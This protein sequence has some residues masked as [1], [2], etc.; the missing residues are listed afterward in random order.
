MDKKQTQVL[1]WA[2]RVRDF[3][4]DHVINSDLA[5]LTALRKELDDGVG[6]LT[7]NAAAQE[8]ITKQSRVQT[9]EITRLRNTL[10]DG[11]LKPIVRMSR[12][13]TLAINGIEI[14]FVLPHFNVDSERLAATGD[15]MVTALNVVVP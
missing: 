10:R 6:Q 13:M 14:T 2:R 8:A 12:T 15:A 9:T 5:E 7:A 3:L 4:V 11:H 1:Q